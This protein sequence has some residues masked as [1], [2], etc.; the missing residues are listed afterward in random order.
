MVGEHFSAYYSDL[1][2]LC[3]SYVKTTLKPW[4]A[5]LS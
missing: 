4:L 3:Y 1:E 2:I 5:C